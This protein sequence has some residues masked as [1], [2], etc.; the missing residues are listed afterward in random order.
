M[1]CSR[2]S[3]LLMTQAEKESLWARVK[4]PKDDEELN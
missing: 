3:F 4:K 1:S 2:P